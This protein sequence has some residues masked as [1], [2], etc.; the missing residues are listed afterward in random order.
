MDALAA[1]DER[2]LQGGRRSRVVL[3]PRRWCQAPGKL[4]LLRGDGGN[5]ARFTGEST[6]ETY[7]TIARG[8][9]GEIGVTVVD[10]LAVLFIFC[11]RGCGR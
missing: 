6:K 9:P 2:R 10:L 3:T 1:Q 5:K 4:T 8:M 11:T 7:K